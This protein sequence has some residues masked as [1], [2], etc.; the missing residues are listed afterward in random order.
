M[1]VEWGK[2]KRG[3]NTLLSSCSGN[4]GARPRRW[5]RE[6]A[7]R[8]EGSSVAGA[9]VRR[10]RTRAAEEMERWKERVGGRGWENVWLVLRQSVEDLGSRSCAYIFT[11][12]LFPP[13]PRHPLLSSSHRP[14]R[15]PD[16]LRQKL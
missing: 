16:G 4:L 1:V 10:V 15:L 7:E 13:L 8:E 6:K 9:R 3:N 14:L 12:D 5:R 2:R 11:K